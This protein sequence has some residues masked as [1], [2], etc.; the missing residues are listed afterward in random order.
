MYSKVNNSHTLIGAT[1]N[2]PV[3]KGQ[4]EGQRLISLSIADN[5]QYKDR[6]TD[7]KVKKT[8]WI[9]VVCYESNINTFNYILEYVKKGSLLAIE[10]SIQ[11]KEQN[12]FDSNGL[13]VTIKQNIVV[14][15]TLK[16]FSK[17]GEE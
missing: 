4:T 12:F 8:N 11:S 3:V 17:K 7:L 10:S 16:N 13:E 15:N 2:D 1:G 14:I 9:D 5:Y 6:E